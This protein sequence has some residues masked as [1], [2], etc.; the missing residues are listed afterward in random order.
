M[1]VSYVSAPNGLGTR[2]TVPRWG[3]SKKTRQN[4]ILHGARQ[5]RATYGLLVHDLEAAALVLIVAAQR[6]QLVP[7][8]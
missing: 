6:R 1:P 3:D 4:P 2:S 8:L 7:S 5:R